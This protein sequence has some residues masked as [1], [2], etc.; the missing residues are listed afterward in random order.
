[1]IPLTTWEINEDL[2]S[3]FVCEVLNGLICEVKKKQG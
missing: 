2:I 3:G 1:M